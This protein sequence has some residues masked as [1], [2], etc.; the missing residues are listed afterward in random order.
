MSLSL[1]PFIVG[2]IAFALRNKVPGF[3][4]T[5]EEAEIGARAIYQHMRLSRIKCV[6]EGQSPYV[7][8]P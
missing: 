8:R 7:D 6:V 2:T 3:K 4:G 5:Q 1:E